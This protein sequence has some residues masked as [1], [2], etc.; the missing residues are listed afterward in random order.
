[1]KKRNKNDDHKYFLLK[2][3]GNSL[4]SQNIYEKYVSNLSLKLRNKK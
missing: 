1:M 2:L 4:L 3:P